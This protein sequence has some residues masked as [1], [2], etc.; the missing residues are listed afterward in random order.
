LYEE[1]E[2][3]VV[4]NASTDGSVAK[5]SAAFPDVCVVRNRVNLG[6]AAAVNTGIALTKGEFI[7]IMN[8]D[9]LVEGR[10]LDPLLSAASR[11]P[12][13]AFFQ[14][15]LLLMSDRQVLNSAG[16]MI[17]I[18]G[19]G[20]CR[21]IGTLDSRS[22]QPE[23]EICF[24]SGACTFI[25]REALREI[26]PVEELF[27]AYGEDEDWGWRA[28]MMGWQSIYVPSSQIFHNW[29]PTLRPGKFHLLEFGRLLSVLKNYSGRTLLLLT[30]LLILVESSVLLYAARNGLLR[31]KIQSYVSLILIRRDLSTRRQR[32]QEGRIVSDRIL[33]GKFVKQIQHPY[34]GRRIRV[35]NRLVSSMWAVVAN[36]I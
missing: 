34:V 27:L 5:M 22:F 25:R 19:F 1:I 31:E 8:P 18:A 16:N 11:Y 6:Y 35:V 36:S 33:M 13:G 12:R 9:T 21:G 23:S 14:P 15:K 24:A 4:D 20:L 10:W 32:V 2:L 17:H 3:V 7:V 26:G 28:S 30:P 29:R